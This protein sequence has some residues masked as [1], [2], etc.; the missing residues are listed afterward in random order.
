[1]N[2]PEAH[3]RLEKT[4]SVWGQPRN[5]AALKHLWDN[6]TESDLLKIAHNENLL[7]HFEALRAQTEYLVSRLSDEDK[8]VQSMP[9]ASPIK[10]HLGHTSWFFET[11]VLLPHCGGYRKFSEEFSFFFNS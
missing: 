3:N 2:S 8:C 9:D 10:W 11:V 5:G 4:T 6:S 7:K 1:M